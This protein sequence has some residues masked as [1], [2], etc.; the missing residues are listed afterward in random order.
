MRDGLL[1]RLQRQLV[2]LRQEEFSRAFLKRSAGRVR[3][4]ESIHDVHVPAAGVVDGVLKNPRLHVAGRHAPCGRH[5]I[6]GMEV[7][8][9]WQAV[10]VGVGG[11]WCLPRFGATQVCAR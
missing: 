9:G 11:P 8:C 3:R 6:C 5:A 2:G 10:L 4:T 7:F 1:L